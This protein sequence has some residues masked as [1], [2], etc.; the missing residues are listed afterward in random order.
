MSLCF[1]SSPDLSLKEKLFSGSTALIKVLHS[2]LYFLYFIFII[3]GFIFS[4]LLRC[5]KENFSVSL[6]SS[7]VLANYCWEYCLE[8]NKETNRVE[9]LEAAMKC[10][11]AIPTPHVRQGIFLT[12]IN[13]STSCFFVYN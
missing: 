9:Y 3:F 6:S 10:A 13:V 8:W 5:L 7:I 12:F 11:N 4:E 1:C 2:I